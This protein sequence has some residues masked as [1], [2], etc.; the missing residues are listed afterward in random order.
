MKFKIIATL[1]IA[2]SASL[3][4]KDRKNLI[5]PPII[6][7]GGGGNTIIVAPYSPYMMYYPGMMNLVPGNTSLQNIRSSNPQSD[8]GQE[9]LD[10]QIR[11]DINLK[12]TAKGLNSTESK[13]NYRVTEISDFVSPKG[14]KFKKADYL[15]WKYMNV[16][17]SAAVSLKSSNQIEILKYLPINEKPASILSTLENESASEY[18]LFI[19]SKDNI[20][21]KGF[22]ISNKEKSARYIEG[23][24]IQGKSSDSYQFSSKED[25]SDFWDYVKLFKK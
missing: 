19:E 24:K 11:E 8:L 4:A 15:I 22:L 25:A 5:L 1:L 2:L 20:N 10:K 16:E 23:R 21:L 18:L 7:G 3:F 17:E 9:I 13:L 6:N 12:G 14:E